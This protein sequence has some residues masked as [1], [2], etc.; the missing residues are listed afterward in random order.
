MHTNLRWI[1]LLAAAALLLAGC[2]V[3]VPDDGN[4]G[5]G[6]DVTVAAEPLGT[7]ESPTARSL[8]VPGN[9][10]LLVEV[11]LSSTAQANQAIYFELGTEQ[12][13]EMVLLDSSGNALASS[14]SAAIFRTGTQALGASASGVA[15]GGL[16]PQVVTTELCR[17]ACIIRNANRSLFYLRVDNV[18]STSRTIDLYVYTK[19]YADEYEFDNNTLSGATGLGGTQETFNSGAIESLGDEDYWEI[20]E[21]G[22]LFFDAV[23]DRPADLE[24]RLDLFDAQGTF[25]ETYAP[26]ATISA[27]DGDVAI[28]YEA[29]NDAA[30]VSGSSQYFLEIQQ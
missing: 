5:G 1:V 3:S 25:V 26:G 22:S 20:L 15:P 8:Q 28:V 12:N 10:S 7:G 13:V 21:P 4:G 2:R 24:L 19:S 6:P 27:L 14:T 18:S 17:G 16:E 29:G 30:G 23:Q 11:T 9:G